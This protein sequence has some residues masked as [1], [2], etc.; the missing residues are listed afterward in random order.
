[1]WTTPRKRASRTYPNYNAKI[2]R[3][4]FV[5]VFYNALPA[6]EYAQINSVADNAI[7]DVKMSDANAKQIYGFY[8]AGILIGSANGVFNPVQNIKRSE[9][10]AIM[11]RM[12][13]PTARK[14]ITLS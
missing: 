10:A 12:F 6:S 4:E 11:T 9:V 13:D 3:S 2:T 1:M 14:T 8:R 7:P 5:K